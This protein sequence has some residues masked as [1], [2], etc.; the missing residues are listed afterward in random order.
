M[1]LSP[2]PFEMGFSQLNITR[3][4]LIDPEDHDRPLYRP[5]HFL[6]MQLPDTQ[7][8]GNY[9]HF[10]KDF[11]LVPERQ[12]LP[13]ELLLE[14]PQTGFVICTLYSMTGIRGGRAVHI[15]DAHCEIAARETVSQL[16]FETGHYSRCWE[17]DIRHLPYGSIRWLE[18]SASEPMPADIAVQVFEIH[19]LADPGAIGVRLEATPWTDTHLNAVKGFDAPA[20]RE[21]QRRAGMPTPLIDLL[22]QA[23][24][25]DARLIIFHPRAAV[26]AGLQLYS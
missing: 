26:L 4:L 22:H 19:I 13:E 15:G 9:C 3:I 8:Q 12:T 20:L 5:V 18:C 7:L 2:N 24:I 16:A 23:A 25:G 1:I 6:Q 11:V 10:G 14:C 21:R 17:I